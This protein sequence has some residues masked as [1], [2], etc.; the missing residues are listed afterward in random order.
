[1]ACTCPSGTTLVPDSMIAVG[2]PYCDMGSCVSGSTTFPKTM[3]AGKQI[4]CKNNSN[5]SITNVGCDVKAGCC[6]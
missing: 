4:S 5:G 1:M 2:D 6:A 3:K